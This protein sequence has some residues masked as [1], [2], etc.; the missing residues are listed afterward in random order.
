MT[1]TSGWTAKTQPHRSPPLEKRM[2]QGDYDL[3]VIGGGSGGI[4]AARQAAGFGAR[5][6]LIE[7]DRLGGT[8]VNV[9]CV[10]KKV[11]W[12]AAHMA[13]TLNQAKEY[14]FE[15]NINSFDW[16]TL[17]AARDDYVKRLNGIYQ[18]NLDNS[19]V[20]RIEGW[21]QFIDPHT[22]GVG[23]KQ[24]TATHL[25][26]A[27]GGRPLVPNIPDRD[28]G[29][30]SDGFF[31]LEKRPGRVCIIGAGYIATELA[32]VLNDLGSD[33]TLVLR[34][35]LL[36]RPFDHTLRETVMAQMHSDGVNILTSIQLKALEKEPNGRI[37]LIREDGGRIEGFDAVI[38][39]IGRT[40]NSDQLALG[41]AGIKT[42]DNG[43]N[44]T[45]R[46]QNCSAAGV[47]AVGDVTGRLQLTPVAIAAS[48]YLMDR[49][50]GGDKEAR[51]D[52][53]AIPSVV[54]SHPPVGTVGL[55]EDQA[56]SCYGDDVK[57]YQNRFTN[58]LYAIT[59]EKR[60]TVVKLITTGPDERVIGCHV[61]GDGADEMIQ[62]FAVALK[63]G[64]TKADFDRT[65]A[66]HPTAAEEL[67]T[68]R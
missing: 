58:I 48:R 26:I 18:R 33:V 31:E 41:K 60:P 37:A 23:E 17:K 29:M 14:G 16:A 40:P 19:N 42:D 6:L 9:G 50:F 52:Y 64:A 30:T 8:C 22:I 24:Y 5:T 39:A 36:L 61:V 13:S 59:E 57:I 62:G 35:E 21:A 43:F 3:I 7:G 38:W 47:Y 15:I 44:I 63:M 34:R 32:G 46:W 12:N 28:L 65:V 20:A 67:V 11:M 25:L 49:L 56:R 66:I 27:T 1:S 68:L 4:A 55:T 2:A 10:P 53:E 54:F 45:D 51:L